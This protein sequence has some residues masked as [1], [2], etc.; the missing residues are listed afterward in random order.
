MPGA[1]AHIIMSFITSKNAGLE[2]LELPDDVVDALIDRQRYFELGAISPDMPYLAVLDGEESEVWADAM[3]LEGVAERIDC[4]V[5]KVASLP[6]DDKMT[7][8]AWLLGF[9]GH[10]VFDVC[11]H[12]V[13]NI[14]AGGEYGDAT[15][16]E[17][18]TCEMH[19]DVFIADK[20]IG[21]KNLGDGEILETSLKDVCSEEDDDAVN[22]LIRDVW[23]AMLKKSTPSLYKMNAPGIDEWYN[24]FLELMKSIEGLGRLGRHFGRGLVYPS[25]GSVSQ[26]YVSLVTPEGRTV[27]YEEL[28]DQ[29]QAHILE[30][31]KAVAQAVCLNVRFDARQMCG[32]NLDTGK[33]VN[34]LFV[35]WRNS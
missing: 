12:P 10:V 18:R 33:D 26:K 24:S 6:F 34:G 4:G 7:A 20:K 15:K 30:W 13:V 28:F 23:D 35:F 16:K 17:H 27:D 3:H 11:M 25:L 32:W 31:W 14:V 2:K 29:A 19:Q 1:Y 21:M 9:V 22:P 5:Q 8:L